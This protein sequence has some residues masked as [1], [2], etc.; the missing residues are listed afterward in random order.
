CP[1]P[2]PAGGRTLSR[3]QWRRLVRLGLPRRAREGA[4]AALAGRPRLAAAGRQPTASSPGR[5]RDGARF[6]S[7]CHTDR[8]EPPDRP[9]SHVLG[10]R[11]VRP[12]PLWRRERGASRCDGT[13]PEGGHAGTGGDRHASSGNLDGYRHPG[14][15]ATVGHATH[16]VKAGPAEETLVKLRGEPGAGRPARGVFDLL[17][18]PHFF[19]RE[20]KKG[21]PCSDRRSDKHS[22]LPPMEIPGD[23]AAFPG[24]WSCC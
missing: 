9:P 21:K 18:T 22:G 14:A 23:A 3:G 5:F 1:R 7:A 12:R 10:Y 19:A 6:K 2:A 8:F 13:P 16:N 4:C 20:R 11:R 15:I 17:M 24:G